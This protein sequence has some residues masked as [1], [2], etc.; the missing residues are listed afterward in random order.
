[1]MPPLSSILK[2]MEKDQ[3][4]IRNCKP[5]YPKLMALFPGMPRII[6]NAEEEK[7]THRF[8]VITMTI[9]FSLMISALI[10]ICIIIPLYIRA[11][12][13]ISQTKKYEKIPDDIYQST[14][15]TSP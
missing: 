7:R 1:M 13:K 4:R 12:Q 8:N 5:G 14:E 9:I 15:T 11:W 3:E 10:G 6:Y 2:S